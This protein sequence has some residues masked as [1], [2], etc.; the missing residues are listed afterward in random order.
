[1][2]EMTVR[3]SSQPPPVT[4]HVVWKYVLRKHIYT[5]KQKK[6]VNNNK[7]WKQIIVQIFTLHDSDDVTFILA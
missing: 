3:S 5:N 6:W 2:A 7:K 4:S 1:M